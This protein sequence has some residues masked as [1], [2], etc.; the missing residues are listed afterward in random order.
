MSDNIPLIVVLPVYEDRE[1]AIILLREMLRL[2]TRPYVVV[3]EDGSI[4][5]PFDAADIAAAGLDGEVLHLVRNVGHQRAIAVGLC[6][7]AANHA[8]DWAVVMD[9]DGEDKPE[10]IPA[11]LEQ[12]KQGNFEVI[13]A[14]RRRRSETVGFRIFYV[15]YKLIFQILTG[16]A[17]SFGNFSVLR[18]LAVRRVA[19]MQELWVHY[20]ASL[21]TS[22]MRIGALPTDRGTRYDGKPHMDFV[23]LTLHGLRSIMVFAED[24]L[25][26]VGLFSIAVAS[27]A[28]VLLAAAVAL[29]LMGY[30]TPGWFT[31][32]VGT[33]L[34][35]VLQA[36]VLTFVT[37]MVCG[38]V[39]ASPQ[40]TL[41]QVDA[42][43]ARVE[44]TL[45]FA[46]Q[47]SARAKSDRA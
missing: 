33:L 25:V 12:L 43:I 10:A 11:M 21:M 7:I 28:I 46:S 3:V 4:V 9:S 15:V 40:V 30:A 44:K 27:G 39:R 22:R 8:F 41:Q 18:P 38:F 20:A 1:S 13:V 32:A 24:V 36:G 31:T 6:Y 26:R 19:A 14:Q 42:L 37:L 2:P 34:L 45:K 16:R 47:R 23:S 17:I 29:K 35:I 5:S